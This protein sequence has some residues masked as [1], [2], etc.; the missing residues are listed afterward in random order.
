MHVHR[1]NTNYN[2]ASAVFRTLL[3]INVNVNVCNGYIACALDRLVQLLFC[4]SGHAFVIEAAEVRPGTGTSQPYKLAL[5]IEHIYCF[6][7]LSQTFC[8]CVSNHSLD[9]IPVPPFLPF[10]SPLHSN[11]ARFFGG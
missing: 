8:N 5:A 10:S 2:G 11:L 3:S 1:L 9:P 6:L 4:K 7:L